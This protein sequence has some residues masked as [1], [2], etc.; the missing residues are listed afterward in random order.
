MIAQRARNALAA[1][2]GAVVLTF[3]AL[4]AHSA[5]A[6]KGLEQKGCEG[7]NAC[8]WVGAY[9][10]KDGVKVSGH[11]RTKAQKKGGGRDD[12]K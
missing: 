3:S 10:R 9:T 6:C 2:F 1:L 11:C 4:P 8:A 5:S 7:N 12:R